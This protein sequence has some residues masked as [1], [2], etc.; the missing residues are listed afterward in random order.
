MVQWLTVFVLKPHM[1]CV[2]SMVTDILSAGVAKAMVCCWF[3][4]AFAQNVIHF[5]LLGGTPLQLTK[6][7]KNMTHDDDM[8][9]ELGYIS[10]FQKHRTREDAGQAGG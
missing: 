3:A 5:R 4:A 9:H 8:T 6:Q 2:R 10:Q 1:I 7:F